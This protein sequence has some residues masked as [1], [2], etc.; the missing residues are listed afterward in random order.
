MYRAIVP[1]HCKMPVDSE[2]RTETQLIS[3][4]HILHQYYVLCLVQAEAVRSQM[5]QSSEEN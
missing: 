1:K 3:F 5:A 2:T 4:F